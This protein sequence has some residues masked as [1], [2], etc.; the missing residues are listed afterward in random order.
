MD[1]AQAPQQPQMPKVDPQLFGYL[2]ELDNCLAKA[3]LNRSEMVQL[4]NTMGAF[5][6]RLETDGA[7]LKRLSERLAV[8]DAELAKYRNDKAAQVVDEVLNEVTK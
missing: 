1:K 8:L 5:I 4:Q 6:R 7:E 2:T 3:P